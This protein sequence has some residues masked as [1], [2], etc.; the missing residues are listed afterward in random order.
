VKITFDPAKRQLD[1]RGLDLA[2]AGEVFAGPTLTVGSD[3]HGEN[4]SPWAS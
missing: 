3:R 4:S 1:N 2:M